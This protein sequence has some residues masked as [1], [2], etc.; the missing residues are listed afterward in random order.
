M[1]LADFSITL[2]GFMMVIFCVFS[3]GAYAGITNSGFETDSGWTV[4][5]NGINAYYASDWSS[6]GTQNFTFYRGTGSIS[7][8]TYAMISQAIDM[9]N[10]IG[11][12]F[13]CQDTGIDAHS[14]NFCNRSQLLSS[15]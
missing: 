3:C 13:D 15:F 5:K 6:E 1:K 4:T 9:T 12:M 10:V 14:L 8:G 2:L 11:F 7:A